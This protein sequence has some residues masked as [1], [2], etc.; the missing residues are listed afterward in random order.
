MDTSRSAKAGLLN[1][2]QYKSLPSYNP[3][4][5]LDVAVNRYFAIDPKSA[6]YQ[7]SDGSTD[8]FTYEKDVQ[9]FM[10]KQTPEAQQ[11]IHDYLDRNSTPLEQNYYAALGTLD[12]LRTSIPQYAGL[13]VE[14][15][16]LRRRQMLYAHYL[17]IA[18]RNDLSRLPSVKEYES[19]NPLAANKNPSTLQPLVLNPLWLQY[20][21]AHPE[22]TR[23]DLVSIPSQSASGNI[24]KT[25]KAVGTTTPNLGALFGKSSTAQS[26]AGPNAYAL[27]PDLVAALNQAAQPQQP[28]QQ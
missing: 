18:G 15:D 14:Q 20:V 12:Q 4:N 25:P 11:Y 1:Q 19:Q 16:D 10:A 21:Q 22:L 9:A 26:K 6:K 23:W 5:N 7:Y 13:T 28:P 27:P 2:A 24:F 8:Y 17:A 3:T